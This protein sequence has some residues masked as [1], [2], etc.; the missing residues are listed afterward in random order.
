MDR[1]AR[2]VRLYG[3]RLGTD[4][5]PSSPESVV[6]DQGI[7]RFQGLESHVLLSACNPVQQAYELDG[8]GAFTAALMKLLRSTNLEKLSYTDIIRRLPLIHE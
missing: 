7:V 4:A 6:V 2:G 1:K 8:R 5:L 3:R